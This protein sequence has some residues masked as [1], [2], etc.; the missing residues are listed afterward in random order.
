MDLNIVKLEKLRIGVYTDRKRKGKPK[1]TFEVMFNPESFS[2]K[3]KN[4]FQTRQGINTSGSQARYSHSCSDQISLKLV[5]DGTGVS[6]YGLDSLTGGRSDS[7]S[8]QINKF[9][10]LCFYMDGEIH[11]PKFLKIQWGD[12]PL[13]IFDCRLD[14]ADIKY[15]SFEKG[16]APLRAELTAMFVEDK[17]ASKRT[18]ME[19]KSSPDLTHTRIVKNGDTLPLLCKE[20]Y[21]SSTHYLRVA[22]V[23]NLDNF[24]NLMPGREIVFPPIET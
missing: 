8:E 16:G 11:E 21:G 7:V 1:D 23:N 12:G 5:F 22:Q 15:T 17:D 24:R 14:S 6:N 19:G 10:N 18:R 20:I 13:Q 3:H 2:M 9:L 4:V